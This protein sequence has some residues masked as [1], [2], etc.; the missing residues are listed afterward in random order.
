METGQ[1][2]LEPEEMREQQ[3]GGEREDR[4]DQS[5]PYFLYFQARA[6]VLLSF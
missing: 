5:K 3:P 6:E 2:G 1:A 4:S